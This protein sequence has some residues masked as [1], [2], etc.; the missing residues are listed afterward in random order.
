M[1]TVE[2]ITLAR[3]PSGI[4]IETTVHTY[5]GRDDGDEPFEIVAGLDIE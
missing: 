4:P 5:E 1:H 3:L 2:R